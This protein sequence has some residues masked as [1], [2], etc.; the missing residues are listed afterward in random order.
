VPNAVS[1]QCNESHDLLRHGPLLAPA[2]EKMLKDRAG[3]VI[4]VHRYETRSRHLG[5]NI[6]NPIR[7]GC[8]AVSGF[9]A[10][11]VAAR[12]APAASWDP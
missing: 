5:R 7:E 12:H 9:V 11:G 8:D 2:P 1:K 3:I 10:G 4:P 6:R